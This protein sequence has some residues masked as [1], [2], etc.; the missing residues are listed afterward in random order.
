MPVNR[1]AFTRQAN[2]IFGTVSAVER[3][4]FASST[5][6]VRVFRTK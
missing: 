3:R 4:E 2:I 1:N 5:K 6:P